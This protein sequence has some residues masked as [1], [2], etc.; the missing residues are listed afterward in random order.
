MHVTRKRGNKL[1]QHGTQAGTGVPMFHSC[2]VSCCLSFP[3]SLSLSRHFFFHPARSQL[4]HL[5]PEFCIRIV[6]LLLFRLVPLL[7]H[8]PSECLEPRRR[9]RW[10][11][12][13]C[14]GKDPF[15]AAEIHGCSKKERGLE[16]ANPR[17]ERGREKERR[18]GE[19][20]VS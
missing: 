15:R 20:S 16:S 11:V 3:H 10:R 9:R 12:S 5:V 6:I 4:F 2:S 13:Q 8:G 17:E 1:E 18:S 14:F 7:F 19:E